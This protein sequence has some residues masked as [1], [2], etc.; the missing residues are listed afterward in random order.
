MET[1]KSRDCSAVD[2]AGDEGCD[3]FRIARRLFRRN[4]IGGKHLPESLVLSWARGLPRKERDEVI[5]EYERM[6]KD[7]FMRRFP[8][9]GETH[10][11]LVPAML[12]RLR[13]LLRE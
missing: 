4:V 13:Q 12:P 11:C 2:G 8:H 5:D 6:V 9:T 7:G 10:V 1:F 3:R